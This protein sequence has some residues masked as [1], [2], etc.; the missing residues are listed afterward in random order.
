MIGV[1]I[2]LEEAEQRLCKFIANARHKASRAAGQP[3]ARLGG[4]TDGETDL[5]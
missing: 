5:E 2:N 1:R 3:N 4:Q